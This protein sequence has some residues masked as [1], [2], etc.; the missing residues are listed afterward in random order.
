MTGNFTTWTNGDAT[1]TVNAS[2]DSSGIKE[3]CFDGCQHWQDSA[4]YTYSSNTTIPSGKIQVKDNA[5]NIT[6][7]NTDIIITKIDK[8]APAISDV[9]GNPVEW[10]NNDATL[11]VHAT[12]D[13]SGVYQYSFD[14]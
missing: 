7:Y 4:S 11:T 14:G 5:G 1:L 12:D 10:T 2:V 8:T 3:Y 13:A 9:T 6:S